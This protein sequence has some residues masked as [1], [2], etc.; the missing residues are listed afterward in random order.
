MHGGELSESGL[1]VADAEPQRQLGIRGVLAPE[2]IGGRKGDL[3]QA[4]P[5]PEGKG[6]ER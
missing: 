4:E 6:E 2:A 1:P 3:E 5:G